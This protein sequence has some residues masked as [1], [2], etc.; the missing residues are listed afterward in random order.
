MER[1]VL[2][3]SLR[4]HYQDDP[5]LEV[6]PWQVTD[7]RHES[8]DSLI[9][10]L[11]AFEIYLD[12]SSF[13]AY[14]DSCESPEELT[15]EFLSDTKLEPEDADYVYLLI[16]ELWRRL[17]PEKQ[18]M[19]LFCDEL[20]HQISLFDSD[21]LETLESLEDAL[22]NLLYLLNEE[23]DKGANSIELFETIKE[24][25]ANHLEDF[26]YDFIDLQIE[27]DNHLYASEILEGFNGT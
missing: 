7:Y 5:D 1:R 27:N 18:T 11:N 23:V 4:L 8:R 13:I 19:S 15:D 26:L 12:P 22:A 9:E 25:C 2:Y 20:D 6:E 10:Q 16:F 21:K 17:L 3:N 14:A 24:S